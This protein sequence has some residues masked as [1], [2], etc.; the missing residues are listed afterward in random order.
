MAEATGE[1]GSPLTIRVYRPCL[2]GQRVPLWEE[3]GGVWHLMSA[4][5]SARALETIV[6][7]RY[8]R[9]MTEPLTICKG[10][11]LTTSCPKP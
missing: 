2:T 5:V 1:M 10:H 7:A 6:E 9:S 3:V 8:C 11:I 4:P